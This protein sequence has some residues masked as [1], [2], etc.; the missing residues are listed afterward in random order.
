ML[1][2]GVTL[3]YMKKDGEREIIDGECENPC[4]DKRREREKRQIDKEQDKKSE[5]REREGKQ[6]C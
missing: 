5:K 6:A 4:E 2:L 1:V 3:I